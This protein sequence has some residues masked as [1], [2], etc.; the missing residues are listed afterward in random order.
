MIDSFIILSFYPFGFLINSGGYRKKPTVKIGT[1]VSRKKEKKKLLRL[2][3][4]I[5]KTKYEKKEKA[6]VNF[7]ISKVLVSN[8]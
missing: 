5:V 6:W 7:L 2:L 8:N 4:P 3:K 1:F